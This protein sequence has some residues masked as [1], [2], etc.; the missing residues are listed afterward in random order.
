MKS[1]HKVAIG[2][3]NDGTI[4]TQLMNDVLNIATHRR[5]Q[6]GGFVSV[7]GTGLLARSRNL[8]VNTFLTET[9]AD[10]LLMMDSDESISIE[11]FD[12]LCAA[13]HDKERPVISA[14]VFAVFSDGFEDAVV[15]PTIY[16]TDE[17]GEH[18]AII[19]YPK[20]TLIKVGAT[21]T[22]ALLIHRSVFVK[23]QQNAT[24]NQG[25]EWCWFVD[26]PI[27]FNGAVRWFG[28][29]L[30]FCRRLA[31]LGIPLHAHTGA[32]LFHHKK[33]WL[34]PKQHAQYLAAKSISST[35]EVSPGV[36][37]TA[38]S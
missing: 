2:V 16:R 35:A 31:I 14:L 11:A 8:L 22:G 34:G 3:P 36:S 32:I 28:E 24:E 17:H 23:F 30:L 27:K 5:D 4:D 13:A 6:F 20:D 19:D 7:Y 38:A 15:V 12:K 18:H 33:S 26:G 10:W 1:H 29:D 9:T 37:G 21:G 25:T